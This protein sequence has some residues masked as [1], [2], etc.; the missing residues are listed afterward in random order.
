M[1]QYDTSCRGLY[2]SVYIFQVHRESR[3]QTHVCTE[4]HKGDTQIVPPL[5]F[6]PFVSFP[7]RAELKILSLQGVVEC[8]E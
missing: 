5:L 4:I 3:Y 1:A 8:C 2:V 7:F 6:V